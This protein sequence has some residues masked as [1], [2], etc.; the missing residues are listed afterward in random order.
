M[1]KSFRRFL[2]IAGTGVLL[3]PIV[4]YAS[5]PLIAT[6]LL[7][8]ELAKNGFR[9]VTIH[10]ER[11]GTTAFQVQSLSFQKKISGALYNSTITNITFE[12]QLNEL[13]NGRLRQIDIER[14]AVRITNTSSPHSITIQDVEDDTNP[15]PEQSRPFT[16]D[17]LLA[18]FPPLPFAQF[19]IGEISIHRS[20]ENSP[21]Q[22]VTLHGTLDSSDKTLK[23]RIEIHGPD[24][25]RYEL[26]M[27]GTSF[28]DATLS[29]HSPGTTPRH[30]AE[31]SSE[32]K[33]IVENTHLQG[34]LTANINPVLSLVELFYP[35]DR[36]LSHLTGT[37][38]TTW[39]STLP[40]STKIDTS[41]TKAI[42]TIDGTFHIQAMLPQLKPY[43]KK[44]EV[45]ARGAFSA[46]HDHVTWTISEE[47][48]ASTSILID[49]VT[50]PEPVHSII[51]QKNHHLS[52]TF[53][54]PLKGL[55]AFN[56][57]SQ[58]LTADGL[59]QS[60]YH[61]PDFPTKL[62]A[63]LT[64]VSGHSLEDLTAQGQ[65]LLSGALDRQLTRHAP[66]QRLEWNFSG[67]LTKKNQNIRILLR[68]RSFLTTS[69]L[70]INELHIP[71]ASLTFT[72]PFIVTYENKKQEWNTEPFQLQIKIPQVSWQDK[73]VR[74]QGIKLTMNHLEGSRS[75]WDTKGQVVILGAETMINDITPPRTN[76]KF[77]FSAQ[78]QFL[79]LRFLGQTAD[80]YISL[81]GDMTQNLRSMNGTLNLK[82]AP[83]LL[84]PVGFNLRENITPWTYPFDITS[85]QISG[86][87]EASW[88]LPSDTENQPFHLS[89]AKAS[90]NVDELGGHYDNVIFDGLSTNITFITDDPWALTQPALV[91]LNKL[92]TGVTISDMSMRLDLEAIPDFTIPRVHIRDFSA[93]M[94]A[95]QF[96]VEDF[97]FSPSHSRHTLTL[98]AK[99]LD[100]GE[101]LN[102]EQQEGLDGTGLLDG[103]IPVTLTTEGVEVHDGLLAARSPGGMIHYQTAEETAAV[104]NETHEQMN[105]VLQA[106][107]NFHYDV[108]TIGANYDHT[109]KLLLETKLQGKN[110]DL[111]RGKPIH[112]NLNV[113][114]NIPALLKSLQ[115]AK[116][117]EGR[118][119]KLL[120]RSEQ[121][122][123]QG[124]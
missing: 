90:I 44:L 70:P 97:E 36:E 5:F 27:S 96:S 75:T 9:N 69:L 117:I 38:S 107:K 99:G 124:L 34:S 67:T 23:T 92:E 119:E 72:Q 83:V 6:A 73:T 81:T 118:I 94:F 108:L 56:N 10:L 37:L 120:Q 43:A 53:P 8:K 109:G 111:Y 20:Q 106:L 100:V 52:I 55:I 88:T 68:P 71:D 30:F 60:E 14:G 78:P 26:T 12:Y 116:D 59:I 1:S 45:T 86:E 49:Q 29:L 33:R 39:N 103:T 2:W 77:L 61:I 91:T 47:S 76:W 121:T 98:E 63:S 84:S 17:E 15:A 114:E 51:P 22:D 65:F 28:G 4:L 32:T 102:L 35:I 93:Q 101:I 104:L 82:L 123:I 80:T 105:I 19:R 85:G 46:T 13:I 3:I 113:E 50:V 79:R 41:I 31:F 112:F 122:L 24:I 42:D 74:L 54:Q 62:R 57:T 115:V 64:H 25:P 48:H 95:G 16:L 58:F 110:P 7:T 89:H 21:L 11:P 66:V 40:L 18:P 87:T